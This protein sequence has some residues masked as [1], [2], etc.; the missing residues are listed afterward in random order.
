MVLPSVCAPRTIGRHAELK[1]PHIVIVARVDD[2]TIAG[3]PGKN[4]R[5]HS[6]VAQKCL[7]IGLDRHH[8]PSQITAR[9]FEKW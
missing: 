9:A 2:A 7:E 3:Q 1:I 4:E 6:Q 5:R 8:E